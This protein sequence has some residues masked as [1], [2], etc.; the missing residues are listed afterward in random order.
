MTCRVS[1]RSKSADV[2]VFFMVLRTENQTTK[3]ETKEN[4]NN[5]RNDN[6]I[7]QGGI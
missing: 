5:K 7:T 3:V 2:F 6:C 4:N 1:E